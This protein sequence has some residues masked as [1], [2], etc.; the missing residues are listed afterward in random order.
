[1]ATSGW[2]VLAVIVLA[3]LWAVVAYNR[4]RE[5]HNRVENAYGQIDV[6]L[7]RRHDLIPNLVE[8]AR[9]YMAH[10]AATL[11]A[12]IRARCTAQGA[13]STARLHPG[14]PGAMGA[15]AMAEQT[16]NGQ[17]GQFR[18][19]AEAYPQLQ[20]DA[21][22]QQLSEELT[23]TENRIGFVRQAYNDQVLDYN[24]RAGSFPDLL[25]ARLMGFAHLDM[26]QATEGAHER[27]VPQVRF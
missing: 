18:L 8:V 3:L 14:Q 11:E 10:E 13:A 19:L 21:R 25:L 24:N 16:L 2:G 12:V 1:M 23:S 17:M 9:G 20:A 15:L 4:L 27:L 6:Q 5:L 26:L 7:K 22:M